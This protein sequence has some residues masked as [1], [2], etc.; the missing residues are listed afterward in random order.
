MYQQT[1]LQ[2][3]NEAENAVA[4]VTKESG[5]D[6]RLITLPDGTQVWL[7]AYSKLTY[8]Q[9]FSEPVRQ[10]S[11]SGEA[12]FDVV[13]NPEQPFIIRTRELSTQ[14]LGTSFN[15]MAYKGQSSLEVVVATGRVALYHGSEIDENWETA[16]D[17][18]SGLLLTPN[19]RGVFRAEEN[20]L[21]KDTVENVLFYTAWKQSVIIMENTSIRDA[22]RILSN[23]YNTKITLENDRLGNCTI[24]GEFREQ[25]LELILDMIS[26]SVQGGYTI[27]SD[28]S[29]LLTG[30]G[31]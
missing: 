6:R 15:V 7:N 2:F 26:T 19:E 31:C 22:V 30:K 20:Q 28:Q 14:V 29:I 16:S 25:S 24:T 18:S 17:L 8:P 5:H 9:E 21:V 10:V 3:S 1:G 11:L 12:F 27:Q 4:L 23:K 13:R